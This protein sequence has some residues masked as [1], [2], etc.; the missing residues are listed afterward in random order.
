MITYVPLV[1]GVSSAR[2]PATSAAG[3]T[4]SAMRLVDVA[5]ALPFLVLVIAIVAIV[6]AGLT[7]VYIGVLVVGWALYARLTRGEMLVAAR[8]GLHAWPRGASA[9]RPRGSSSGT[10]CRISC[11]RTS[12]SRRPTS[13]STSSCWPASPTWAWACSR[14]RPSSGAMVAEGQSVLLAGLVGGDDPRTRHRRAR[15]RVQ[16]DRRRARGPARPPVPADRMSERGYTAARSAGPDGRVSHARTG[17]ALVVN[18][19]S[20]SRSAPARSSGWWAS[21]GPA[22]A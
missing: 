16:H 6:G 19:V 20:A 4:R 22:R 11:A 5:I 13:S 15:R 9:T 14:Q 7:G 10:R 8:A 21:R 18:D 17:V 12:S 2:T 3:S 1:I